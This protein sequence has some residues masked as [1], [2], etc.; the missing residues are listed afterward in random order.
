MVWYKQSILYR[1]IGMLNVFPNLILQLEHLFPE[2]KLDS[3]GMFHQL[4][5]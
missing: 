1:R 4:A 2:P 5:D 3:S